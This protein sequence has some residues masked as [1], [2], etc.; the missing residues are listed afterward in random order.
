MF[1]ILISNV[2]FQETRCRFIFIISRSHSEQFSLELL[3]TDDMA[4]LGT[5]TI[6]P[7]TMVYP[8]L[9]ESGHS[10]HLFKD[11]AMHRIQTC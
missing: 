2:S 1:K 4:P 6:T 11:R 8:L 5:V 10:V 9:L 7:S 3:S